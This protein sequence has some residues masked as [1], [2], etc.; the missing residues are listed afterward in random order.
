MFFYNVNVVHGK[1]TWVF[2]QSQLLS[3]LFLQSI[4]GYIVVSTL[5]HTSYLQA[6]DS[7]RV[8]VVYL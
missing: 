5:H 1:F 7:T 3:E 8:K 4:V 6:L 2:A